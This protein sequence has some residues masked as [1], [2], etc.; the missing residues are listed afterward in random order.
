MNSKIL[1]SIFII[2]FI[3]LGCNNDDDEI[4]CLFNDPVQDL[5][6]LNEKITEIENTSGDLLKYQFIDQAIYQ[7]SLFHKG[8]TVFIFNNCCPNCNTVVPVHNCNGEFIGLIG[9][10]DGFINPN[11]VTGSKSI[12]F[13]DN[14]ECPI[15][16]D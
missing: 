16:I 9:P 10:A 14:S 2:P 6:W 11:R 15:P 8:K 3:L 12:W 13:P 1:M 7:E 4:D 5:S